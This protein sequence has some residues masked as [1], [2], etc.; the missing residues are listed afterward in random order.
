MVKPQSTG[1]GKRTTKSNTVIEATESADQPE[2]TDPPPTYDQLAYGKDLKLY[3]KLQSTTDQA[4]RLVK[5]AVE[6]A[7]KK[8]AK[9]HLSPK[10]YYNWCIDHFSPRSEITLQLLFDKYNSITL[11]KANSMQDYLSKIKSCYEKIRAAGDSVS[12]SSLQTKVLGNLTT[13]YHHFKTTFYLTTT[14]ANGRSFDDL[15]RILISEEYSRKK[16][17]LNTK[18]KNKIA[19]FV[20]TNQKKK[21]KNNKKKNQLPTCKTCNRKHKSQCYVE[22]EK[23]P[24]D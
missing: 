5:L 10:D 11:Q 9:E 22:T 8:R 24:Q 20:R 6:P 17:G 4:W 16:S 12:D 7:I 21:N 3:Y 13:A 14:K 23:I 18:N 19:G 15:S 2:G 1:K